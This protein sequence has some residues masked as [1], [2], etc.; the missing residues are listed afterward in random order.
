MANLIST[1]EVKAILQISGSSYDDFIDVMIPV[2]QSFT[3]KYTNLSEY[4]ASLYPALKLPLAQMIKYQLDKPSNVQSE[5]IGN[6]SVT[7]GSTGYPQHI[8]NELRP[9]RRATFISGSDYYGY[10]AEQWNNFEDDTLE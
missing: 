9:F 1:G 8:I 3:L 6:Y 10:S 7:Y 5:T 4:S 2:V